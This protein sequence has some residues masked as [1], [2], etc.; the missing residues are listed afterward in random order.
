M[1]KHLKL[2]QRNYVGYTG[3]IGRWAFVGG[4]SVEPI[5]PIE[6]IRISANFGVVEL[7]ASGAEQGSPS[8]SHSVVANHRTR[9][10]LRA[11]MVRQT[12][13]EKVEETVR[14][15]MGA[16]ETKT[17]IARETLEEIAS[18]AGIAG[19]REIAATWNVRSKSIPVLLQMILDAQ[20]AYAAAKRATL[21]GRGIPVEEIE[22]IL[23]PAA[24]AP[25]IESRLSRNAPRKAPVRQ[26]AD[27]IAQAAATG[28]LAAAISAAD[29]HP[30]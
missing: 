6:R 11:P 29:C 26:G 3:Q 22:R 9:A 4:V 5:P 18:A 20:D 1:N 2:T 21:M 12:V 15:V 27:P 24:Q 13:E 19:L 7:D 17:L 23:T 25:K 16:E 10:E 14:V 28:D 8:P 30:G